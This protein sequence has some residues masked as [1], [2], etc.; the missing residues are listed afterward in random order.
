MKIGDITH[1]TLDGVE[2]RKPYKLVIEL[3]EP[4][5]WQRE[6]FPNQK[7]VPHVRYFKTRE[8]AEQYAKENL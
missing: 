1:V 3:Q 2:P 5:S 7:A 4:E 6:F 8:E